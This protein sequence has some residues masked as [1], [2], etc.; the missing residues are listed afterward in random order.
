MHECHACRA[1]IF[2]LKKMSMCTVPGTLAIADISVQAI[3]TSIAQ[4]EPDFGA[5]KETKPTQITTTWSSYSGAVLSQSKYM[6]VVL[7]DLVKKSKKRKSHNPLCHHVTKIRQN[8]V[9]FS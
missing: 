9:G 8:K 7:H 3:T 1:L 6:Y 2:S 5:D 4:A